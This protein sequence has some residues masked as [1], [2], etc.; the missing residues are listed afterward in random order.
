MVSGQKPQCG[1]V[2]EMGVSL[3]VQGRVFFILMGLSSLFSHLE[4]FR[5]TC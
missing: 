1:A 5:Q 3:M 4:A 2:V